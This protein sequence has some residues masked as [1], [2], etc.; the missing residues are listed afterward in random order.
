MVKKAGKTIH[1]TSAYL[2]YHSCY[3]VVNQCFQSFYGLYFL[4]ETCIITLR[5]KY[6][7]I[8]YDD[9]SVETLELTEDGTK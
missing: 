8:E 5:T 3:K 9:G 4:V 2:F 7:E 6:V 1:S